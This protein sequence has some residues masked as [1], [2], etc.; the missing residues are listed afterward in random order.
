MSRGWSRSSAI[1]G[2]AGGIVWL[3]VLIPSYQPSE[4]RG[5]KS[6][7]RENDGV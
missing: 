1:D 5:Y 2:K 3:V 6:E 4:I 7:R